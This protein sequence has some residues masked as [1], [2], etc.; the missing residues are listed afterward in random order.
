MS[1]CP[2]CLDS[3]SNDARLLCKHKMCLQC[4]LL[5]HNVVCPVCRAPLA[6]PLLSDSDLQK[7]D[8][9][10]ISDVNE[11]NNNTSF[12]IDDNV[13]V[14]DDD[15]FVIDD[16]SQDFVY[17]VYEELRNIKTSTPDELFEQLD[18]VAG[19][20]GYNGHEL[21]IGRLIIKEL[22]DR[23]CDN[24]FRVELLQSHIITIMKYGNIEDTIRL[25]QFVSI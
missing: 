19:Y 12:V 18:R 25:C 21:D 1:D 17:D 13:I 3:V 24:D 15:V 7:M 2:I 11:I 23:V 14:I 20:M 4:V 5:L 16:D 6:S 10:Y 8:D 9:K 22:I